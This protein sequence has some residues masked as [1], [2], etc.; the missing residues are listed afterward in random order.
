MRN[1]RSR[2]I[3]SSFSGSRS[4]SLPCPGVVAREWLSVSAESV[5]RAMGSSLLPT[6]EDCERT[7]RA[8]LAFLNGRVTA[9][10]VFLATFLTDDALREIFEEVEET[11]DE[12][13]ADGLSDVVR[14]IIDEV[15]DFVDSDCA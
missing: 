9:L 8:R 4:L 13:E 12:T 5:L 7:D 1:Y 11:I 3:P 15:A 6:V 10:I 14:E 2:Y